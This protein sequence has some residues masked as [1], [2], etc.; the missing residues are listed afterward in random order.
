MSAFRWVPRLG[1][2][3]LARNARA[4]EGLAELGREI[5]RNLGLLEGYWSSHRPR[6]S[7][8]EFHSVQKVL[9]AREMAL[10]R[11]PPFERV[12]YERQTPLLERYINSGRRR[13]LDELYASLQRLEEIQAD[14]IR[15]HAADERRA[16][17][18]GPEDVARLRYDEFVRRAPFLWFEAYHL[19][20]RLL[21]EKTRY[22][23]LL[24]V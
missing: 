1:Q 22:E 17:E 18:A 7:E 15:V 20:N 19:I 2:L 3:P 12:A 4:S 9:Y 5:R 14:L 21:A 11:L 23:D 16:S 6:E 13:Q 8:D 10:D 24:G